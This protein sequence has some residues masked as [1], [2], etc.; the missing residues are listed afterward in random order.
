MYV[1][2][3]LL[4]Y[5]MLKVEHEAEEKT[6]TKLDRVLCFTFSSLSLLLVLGLLVSS[7]FKKIGTTGYWNKPVTNTI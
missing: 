4:G 3:Y 5:A 2:G 1:I 6:Y 7:W